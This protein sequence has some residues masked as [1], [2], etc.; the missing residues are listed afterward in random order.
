MD[1]APTPNRPTAA[2]FGRGPS[3]QPSSQQ[4]SHTQPKRLQRS[5]NACNDDDAD[6]DEMDQRRVQQRQKQ[7]DYGYNTQGYHNMVRLVQYDPQLRNGGVLPLEPPAATL[8]V[9]K[10]KWDV[11]SRKWRR[12]LHMF[13]DVYIEGQ[14]L[15]GGPTMEQ[16]V[17]AQRLNWL[18][19]KFKSAPKL[20]RAKL[21]AE[22]IFAVRDSSL[23]PKKLPVE[24]CMKHLLRNPSY[25]E[26]VSNVVPDSASS[27]T[28][29]S[30]NVS[31]T[32][33]GI[34]IHVAPSPE[35]AMM[36]SCPMSMSSQG[37]SVSPRQQHMSS[38]SSSS[39]MPALRSTSPLRGMS[40][41]FGLSPPRLPSPPPPY[42]AGAVHSFAH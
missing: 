35:A 14:E 27:L 5:S 19:P 18:A 42:A 32:E 3:S 20:F 4:Q 12:A 21:A 37:R 39:V 11:L 2:R 33:A 7:I 1:I 9:S 24:P 28:R 30:S 23:V 29:G 6:G 17:A 40:P 15:Q 26:D 16:V 41:M 13:D 36:S 10:K 8:K 22:K 31:P 25:F 34:K 38:A